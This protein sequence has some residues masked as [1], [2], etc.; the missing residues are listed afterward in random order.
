MHNS[1]SFSERE[2][3]AFPDFHVPDY[4]VPEKVSV[5]GLGDSLTQGVGMS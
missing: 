3:T 4:F 1:S 2:K 5:I